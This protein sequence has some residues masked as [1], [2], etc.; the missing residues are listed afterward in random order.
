MPTR[1]YPWEAAARMANEVR[2]RDGDAAARSMRA[3]LDVILEGSG[4]A[5]FDEAKLRVLQVLTVASRAAYAGGTNGEPLFRLNIRLVNG[6]IK[7]STRR[8][9]AALSV[10]TIQD[11]VALIPDRDYVDNA[12]IGKAFQ[13]IR[14]HCLEPV[15]R[16]A[17]A[18]VVGCSPSHLSR[19]FT[20]ATGRTFKECVLECRMEK[21]KE[22]LERTGRKVIDIALDL[23]YGDPNYFSSTFKRVTGVTPTQ[24]RRRMSAE[25]P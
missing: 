20:R 17:V 18:A 16:D 15:S 21:A 9:L 12:G 10:K 23:G 11:L 4:K 2:V 3:L 13:Y 5:H 22:L 8:R 6:I 1:D 24:Y 14:T 7:A 19:L 25:R